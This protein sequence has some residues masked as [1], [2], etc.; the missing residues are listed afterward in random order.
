MATPLSPAARSA[1]GRPRA[2][3]SRPFS[4]PARG[5][6]DIGRDQPLT[7]RYDIRAL[8][9]D[10]SLDEFTRVAPATPVFE[11]AFAALARGTL[12]ATA[13]GP[14]AVEDLVPGMMI[15]TV[16]AG[17]Q[18][19]LWVGAM[20]VYP[21]M[22][23]LGPG[24]APGGL[25]AA[26]LT[27]MSADAFGFGRPAPDLVLGPRARVLYRSA[28]CRDLVGAA[29]AF[30]PARAFVDGDGAI[31]VTPVSP[32]RVFHLAFHGQQVIRANG[33]EVESYH[34]GADPASMMT[35]ET[36]EL[37]LALFPHIDPAADDGTGGFGPLSVPR[38]TAFELDSLRAA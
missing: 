18:P 9:G 6:A 10:G 21:D 35:R 8:A 25:E 3:A 34:P 36:L 30:A 31:R 14:V 7:R 16:N 15:E 24:A 33:M 20:T 5:G 38:L 4:R 11:D 17:P 1:T 27:R 32:V 12:V 19:L 28:A 22:R 13:E 37:F 29:E 23:G 26:S 2:L